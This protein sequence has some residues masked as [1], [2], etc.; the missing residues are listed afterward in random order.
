MI[1]VEVTNPEKDYET[2]LDY[3]T[4]HG[5]TRVTF[6]FKDPKRKKE[7]T[8]ISR[9]NGYEPARLF[10]YM[11]GSRK[12]GN[13]IQRWEFEQ[14]ATFKI[15]E[16][17]TVKVK[18]EKSW[19]RVLS[20]L[21]ESGLWE[22]IADKIRIGL[23]IG[24]DK[25]KKASKADWEQITGLSYTEEREQRVAKIAEIDD[26]LTYLNENGER[27]MDTWFVWNMAYPAKIKT[28]YFGKYNTDSI[29]EK[30][31]KALANKEKY[32]EF[33]AGNDWD[34]QGYDVSFEYKPELNKAWY[35]EEYRGYGNGHYYIALNS[36][37]ALFL[38]DD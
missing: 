5:K 25:I 1:T 28:M 3:V 37:H 33:K 6:I 17:Q 26:R 7:T 23:E 13:T 21:E 19:G 34:G 35:S 20:M 31:A 15:H 38:E 4:K 14:I 30:I 9:Y 10:Q 24:Y 36:T 8:R 2:L 11:S 18:W 16:K 22:N 27:C 29:R 32:S 12:W